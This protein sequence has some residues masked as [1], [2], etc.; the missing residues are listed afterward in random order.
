MI[1]RVNIYKRDRAGLV[2]EVIVPF[3]LVILGCA[4]CQIQLGQSEDPVLL[5]PEAYPAPQTVA[6]NQD[7]VYGPSTNTLS[8]KD[9]GYNLPGYETVMFPSY[10]D[11]SQLQI[12]NGWIGFY[13]A[14]ATANNVGDP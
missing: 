6:F 12:S 1:K 2:C 11:W 3:F 4:I 13:T 5:T 9:F 14:L 7:F 10:N 8:V